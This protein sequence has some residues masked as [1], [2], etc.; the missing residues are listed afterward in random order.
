MEPMRAQAWHLR[1]AP[2]LTAAYIRTF[3]PASGLTMDEVHVHFSG[4]MNS[5]EEPRLRQLVMENTR[6]D[7]KTEIL[8]PR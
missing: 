4:M 6:Y 8:F 1:P 7:Q 3:I 5:N 2:E